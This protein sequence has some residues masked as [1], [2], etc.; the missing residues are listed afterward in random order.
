M[1]RALSFGAILWDVIGEREYLGGAPFNL[2]AHLARWGLESY[3]V[4][5]TGED[6]RGRSAWDAMERLEVHTDFAR[7]D[8]SHETGIAICSLDDTGSAHYEVP[9]NSAYRYIETDDRML[10]AIQEK[11]FDVFCFGSFEQKAPVSREAL[12]RLLRLPFGEVFFDVNIRQGFYPRDVIEDSLRA[13]TIVKLNDDEAVL[14]SEL[15]YE[16]A[17]NGAELA[18][19]FRRDYG[20]RVLCITCGGDGCDVYEEKNAIHAPQTP[21]K[22]A[23]TVGAGDAFSGAFL[24]T[25]LET[26]D[27]ALA[28]KRANRLGGFV[29]SQSG[30]IPDYR[31]ADFLRETDAI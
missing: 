19:A 28:A 24:A 5:K 11:Q 25:L 26:G 10:S 3:I 29:A 22:V 6:A 15:L 12:R 8:P 18:D 2:A 4:T 14:L 13:A 23:D 30:A 21:V 16:S 20:V 7:Q 1:K 9:L 17:L 27:L 31:S